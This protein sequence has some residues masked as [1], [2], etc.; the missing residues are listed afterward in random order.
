[1]STWPDDPPIDLEAERA[2]RRFWKCTDQGNGERFAAQC[3]G[4]ARY[5]GTWSKWII[6]DGARWALDSTCQVDALAKRVVRSIYGEA[7]RCDDD[8]IRNSISK[9]ATKSEAAGRIHAM[10]DLARSEPGIPIKHTELD[11]DPWL[12]TVPNGTIDLR[13]GKLGPHKREHLITRMSA[14]IY[15]PQARAPRWERFLAEVQPDPEVRSYLHRLAGYCATGVIREHVLPIFWGAGRNGKGVWIRAVSSAI[16]EAAIEIAPEVVMAPPRMSDRHP[17]ELTTLCGARMASTSETEEGRALNVSRVKRLTGG[18]TIRARRMRE[19]DWEFV[20]THKIVLSTNHKPQINETANAIWDRLH[21]VPWLA[22]FPPDDPRHDPELGTKL[23]AE[24]PGILAW[25]VRGCLEWQRAGLAPPAVVREATAGY[26]SSS[27][28]L[29]NWIN[30]CC[31]ESESAQALIAALYKSYEKWCEQNGEPPLSGRSFGDK[32]AERG[33]AADMGA[34]GA[35]IR[36]GIGLK[37]REDR[38]TAN[39]D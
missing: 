22:R 17:T 12:L 3:L 21:L 35:R 11:A 27:D 15:E 18:D 2:R 25:V 23:A 31:V 1:M 6:W 13:T 14:V 32:L 4:E 34:K 30:D 5:V 9:W 24:A 7:E 8:A 39:D 38:F 10:V 37:P 20:P 36:R 29:S 28:P 16:G 19:D 33:Y 26:R